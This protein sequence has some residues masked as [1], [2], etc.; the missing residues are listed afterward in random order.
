MRRLRATQAMPSGVTMQQGD[1]RTSVL[2]YFPQR[3]AN[4]TNQKNKIKRLNKEAT[5][6][7]FF[8]HVAKS[9]KSTLST[10]IISTL[11]GQVI[12]RTSGA[13]LARARTPTGAQEARRR[14]EQV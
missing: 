4:L 5:F 12:G 14:G 2:S 7:T 3:Y 6:L 1:I 9:T 8:V 10:F 11:A 13:T